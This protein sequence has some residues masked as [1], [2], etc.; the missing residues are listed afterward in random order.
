MELRLTSGFVASVAG[1]V[2]AL[3]VWATLFDSWR[4]DAFR[5]LLL[6]PGADK[7]GHFIVYAALALAV[8]LVLERAWARGA[9]LVGPSVAWFVGLAEELRQAG[10]RGRTASVE[11]LVANTL[12]VVVVA[13]V[14]LYRRRSSRSVVAGCLTGGCGP[15]WETLE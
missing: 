13:V 3:G 7:V 1:V 2:A 8:G 4:A 12:G 14:L 6:A 10:V 5:D 15:S 9:W 11:D